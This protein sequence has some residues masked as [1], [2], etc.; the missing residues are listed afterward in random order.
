MSFMHGAGNITQTISPVEKAIK[1]IQGA[2]AKLAKDLWGLEYAETDQDCDR[3]Y[4]ECNGLLIYW[5]MKE[6][7]SVLDP[8]LSKFKLP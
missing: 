3:I 2:A 4:R 1:Y 8:S 5:T 7:I 6:W